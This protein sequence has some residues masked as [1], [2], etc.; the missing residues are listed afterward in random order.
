MF[1]SLPKLGRSHCPHNAILLETAVIPRPTP[2]PTPRSTPGPPSGLPFVRP[3]V[4]PPV[5][6]PVLPPVT[7]DRQSSIRLNQDYSNPVAE[8]TLVDLSSYQHRMFLDWSRPGLQGNPVSG[9]DCIG[10]SV[11][12]K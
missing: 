7:L 8:Q 12:S 10:F 4:H 5:R 2:R 9:G 1:G 6:P 11:T 3:P